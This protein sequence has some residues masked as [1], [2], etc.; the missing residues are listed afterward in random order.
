M[1]L[2]PNLSEVIEI[3]EAMENE[4]YDRIQRVAQI[5]DKENSKILVAVFNSLV[6]SII[7]GTLRWFTKLF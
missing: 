2:R 3:D 7:A 6:S 1:Y 4:F 5:I